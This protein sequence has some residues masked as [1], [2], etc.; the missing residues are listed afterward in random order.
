MF[1]SVIFD[2]KVLWLCSYTCVQIQ[3]HRYVFIMEW[4]YDHNFI[5]CPTHPYLSTPVQKKVEIR[6]LFSLWNKVQYHVQC[7][8]SN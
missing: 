5:L 2:D 8:I 1:A 6:S 3:V 4:K 7:E